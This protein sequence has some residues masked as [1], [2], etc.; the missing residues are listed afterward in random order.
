MT[1]QVTKLPFY[2]KISKIDMICSA[3]PGLTEDL[4]RVQKKE[5]SATCY[6]C[7]AYTLTQ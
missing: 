2:H 5:F 4:Y 7:V 6:T 1:G 3:K